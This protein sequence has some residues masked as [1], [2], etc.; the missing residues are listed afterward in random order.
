MFIALACIH[1]FTM[2]QHKRCDIQLCPIP[3]WATFTSKSHSCNMGT[4]KVGRSFSS[5]L[6][7][8]QMTHAT[9]SLQMC[10]FAGSVRH[11]PHLRAR[12]W[13][14][15]VLAVHGIACG[16]SSV[17]GP[18]SLPHD[19]FWHARLGSS[20][21][22]SSALTV[23]HNTRAITGHRHVKQAIGINMCSAKACKSEQRQ[24]FR[25]L[26]D[27]HWRLKSLQEKLCLL[28][29][30]LIKQVPEVHVKVTCTRTH[31]TTPQRIPTPAQK[32]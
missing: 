4:Y 28:P 30:H 9:S 31:L 3:L 10:F 5:M 7:D 22:N 18:L 12:V 17:D 1:C 14:Y 32:L 19:C 16:H 8:T 6:D 20:G 23:T 2:R 24:C 27:W 11:V 29:R 25:S 15:F 26:H 21:T 13:S